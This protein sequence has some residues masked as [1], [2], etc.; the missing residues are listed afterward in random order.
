MALNSLCSTQVATGDNVYVKSLLNGGWRWDTFSQTGD[1][2]IVRWDIDGTGWTADQVAALR[3]AAEQSF[4]AWS[5]VAHINFQHAPNANSAEILLHISHSK[6]IANYGGY[7]G[8]PGEATAQHSVPGN[9]TLPLT[10]VGRAHV[11]VAIDGTGGANVPIWSTSGGKPVISE[12]GGELITHEIGHAI[13]LAHPHD[14]GSQ[15]QSDLFPGV[16]GKTPA[17][18]STPI[19]NDLGDNALNQKLYTI[20]SYNEAQLPASSP[21]GGPQGG[22]VSTPMAFD[23]AATQQIYGANTDHHGGDDTYV[24]PEPGSAQGAAWQCIWDTGGHDRIIYEGTA[25]AVIDLRPA[26]LDDSPTGGGMASYTWRSTSTDLQFGRGGTI[27]AD[28]TNALPDQ[29]GVTGVVIEDAWGGAGSDSI[30]GSAADNVLHGGDG[31]DVLYGLEGNDIFNGDPGNDVMDGGPGNDKFV[32]ELNFGADH[33]DSFDPD[34]TDGQDLLDIAETG[35]TEASFSAEVGISQ[36]GSDTE[37]HIGSNMITL[38]G[39]DAHTID[40]SDF[41]FV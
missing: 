11:Y 28:V 26:T 41:V 18:A 1:T 24:L 39:V 16:D 34:P 8:T 31:N 40:Q 13:G 25:N 10:D 30:W 23:I 32:F 33:I 27:A 22:P 36:A 12:S 20:M 6:D 7:A 15:G 37:I 35:V 14:K 3:A 38:V 9:A 21:A 29:G 17:G 2:N 5:D 4:S 19:Q